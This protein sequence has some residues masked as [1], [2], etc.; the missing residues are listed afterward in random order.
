MLLQRIV[1][2]SDQLKPA[3]Q[4]KRK[5]KEQL[6]EKGSKNRLVGTVVATGTTQKYI[7][8]ARAADSVDQLMWSLLFSSKRGFHS[9]FPPSSLF[10]RCTK[11]LLHSEQ[12]YIG[13]KKE[14]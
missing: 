9:F 14:L 2:E 12:T 7:K 8:L 6:W 1:Y 5:Q 4:W 11:G 10:L 3:N 13:K